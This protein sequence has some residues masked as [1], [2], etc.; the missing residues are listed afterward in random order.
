[1]IS[2]VIVTYNNCPTTLACLASLYAYHTGGG[3]EVILVDN[4]SHDGTVQAV[5]DAYPSVRLLAQSH[6]LGFGAANNIGAAAA[7]GEF[8]LL[9]NNDTVFTAS[10][11][12]RLADVL[13]SNPRA[14]AAAPM[15]TNPDGSFQ[16]SVGFTPSVRGEW[17]T[18]RLQRACS[19]GKPDALAAAQAST[20]EWVTAAALMI[21]ADAFRKAD[22]FD[23]RFFMY[24]EDVDLCLRLREGSGT[25][26][27]DS[28]IAVTHIGGGSWNTGQSHNVMIRTAYR[29]S[30][31]LFYAKHH[32]A[33]Q[34][35][36]LRGFLAV[37]Y[38]V[39]GVFGG[40]APARAFL[41]TLFVPPRRLLG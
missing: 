7:V 34:N 3:F 36:L 1:M 8:L 21:R 24:F 13:R 17:R 38:C 27:Y 16:V 10:V 41:R 35:L 25:I 32:G 39:P 20:P 23:E 12:E 2:V 5:A 6:N 29:H 28:S 31:L 14:S 30:Q 4:A 15:L 33:A 18:Q 40:D 22:G 9:L 11:L 19:L 26:L 37:K